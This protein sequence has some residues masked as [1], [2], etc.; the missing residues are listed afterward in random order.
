MKPRNPIAPTAAETTGP[1]TGHAVPLIKISSDDLKAAEARTRPRNLEEVR[2]LAA[3]FRT[4]QPAVFAY[5]PYGPPTP[6]NEQMENALICA[7]ARRFCVV[8]EARYGTAPVLI[9]PEI[10]MAEAK[11]HELLAN[12]ENIRGMVTILSATHMILGAAK[13]SNLTIPDINRVTLKVLT[14][15]TAFSIAI[16]VDQQITSN[17]N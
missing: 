11:A 2:F 13:A 5:V 6:E 15:L 10:R 12:P 7:W 4:T 8:L 14:L 16:W 1:T 3:Q 9:E 17:T